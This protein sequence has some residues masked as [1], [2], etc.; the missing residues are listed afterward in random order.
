LEIPARGCDC[1]VHVFG[2]SARYPF[3]PERAYTPPDAS[4]DELLKIQEQL[5]LERVVVVQPSV[6]GTDNSCTLDALRRLGARARGVVVIDK[7]TS[8]DGMREAGVRGV[9]VNLHTGGVD[10]AAT[11]QRLLDEMAARVARLGWHLQIFGRTRLLRALDI[12]VERLT[13][14]IVVDHFGLAADDDDLAW[15]GEQMASGRL[16]V[17][18]SAPHRVAFDTGPL[19]RALIAANP[20]RCLWGSDWPHPAVTARDPRQ[21]QPFDAVDDAAALARLQ[22]WASVPALFRKILVDNPARLYDF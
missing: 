18:L 9:R 12:S 16:Y 1:H 7:A 6:Y 10:D 4:I 20:E 3:A 21:V 2:P 19:A 8:L 22:G 5:G 15:L 17:K 11:A 13:L 14:P